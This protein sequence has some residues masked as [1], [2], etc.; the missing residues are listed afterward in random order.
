MEV[1]VPARVSIII[2]TYNRAGSLQTTLECI[3][4]QTYPLDALEA[5]VADDGSSDATSEVA[6]A[7][8]PFAVRYLRQ[9]HRGPTAA[10]N[11]AAAG[12]RADVLILLDDDI[13][14]E[15]GFAAALVRLHETHERVL[16]VAVFL[17]HHRPGESLFRRVYAR[18]TATTAPNG[19]ATFLDFRAGACSLRREDYFDIGMMQDLGGGVQAGWRDL[20][21]AYRA[22]CRGYT[23]RRSPRA[24][25]YHDD[26][27]IDDLAT[28]ARRLE[29]AG[30]WA[31]RL[32]RRHPGL[33]GQL[34]LLVDKRPVALGSDSPALI[35][36][37][38]LRALASARPALALLEHAAHRLETRFPR[39]RLLQPLYRWIVGGY[40]YRGY[41]RGLR[42]WN[43][44]MSAR[45]GG[46]GD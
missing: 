36:R 24:R 33:D 1:S 5:I 26:H 6:A 22:H 35:A 18:Q 16:G 23:F 17:P 41:R 7:P 31:V 21:F 8:F 40:I 12:S 43:G 39:E 44:T 45:Q 11:G 32:V 13:R 30:Y 42:E 25:C 9:E 37:K 2:P 15:P 4:K 3:G 14:I 28:Y 27:A 34:P 46:T 38:L 29:R 10:R 19:S 20:E